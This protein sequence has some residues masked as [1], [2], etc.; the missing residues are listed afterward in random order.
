MLNATNSSAATVRKFNTAGPCVTLGPLVRET[1]GF[2][3]FLTGKHGVSGPD[4]VLVEKRI[5]K[6]SAHVTACRSCRDHSNTS[7]PNGYEN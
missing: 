7:Y 5:A 4:A 3:V 6:D 1:A 2:F